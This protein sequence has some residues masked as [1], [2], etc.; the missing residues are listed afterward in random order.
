MPELS[1]WDRLSEADKYKLWKAGMLSLKLH[2]GQRKIYDHI[3]AWEKAELK[4]RTEELAPSPGVYADVYYACCAR[5]F[6]KDFL[7][8]LMATE[9]CLRRKN[10][11]FS[12]GT[13]FQNDI[14]DICIALMEQICQDAPRE[15]RP[16]LQMANQAHPLRYYFPS[17]KSV[18]KLVGLDRNPDGLRGRHSDGVFLSEAAFI[19][20]LE[21]TI[22][23]VVGAMF[24]NRPW[25]NVLMNSTPPVD[26][27]HASD[28]VFWP[29]CELR[30][31]YTE[32]TIYD[33]PLLSPFTIEEELR[34]KGGKDSPVA[35]REYLC[36]RVRQEDRVVLPE[37]S[38]AKHVS[39]FE[40]PQFA[41]AFTVL[42]PGVVDLCGV[43]LIV[44]DFESGRLLVVDEWAKA[45]ASTPEVAQAIRMLEGQ[46]LNNLSYWEVDKFKQN[47]AARYSDTEARLI[48]DMRTEHQIAIQPVDKR[49]ADAAIQALRAALTMNRILIHP[50]CKQLIAHC[51]NAVWNKTRSS[52]E[53]SER[54]G[55]YDLVDVIKYAYRSINR[56]ANPFPPPGAIIT[57]FG[58]DFADKHVPP[59]T[60][61]TRS[62]RGGLQHLAKLLPGRFYKKR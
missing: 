23:S 44:N 5:R 13:A 2:S 58:T 26:P 56:T 38:E 40:I 27:G 42:D 16:V 18:L 9:K 61:R 41:Q 50:R 19:D 55:H 45:G 24:L 32:A 57:K 28:T 21:Y 22:Q 30:G 47:P 11:V 39:V 33:N 48:L 51:N 25:A 12:Y 53:R 15:I 62:N 29:D 34:K 17:T 36:K 1:P 8:L 46:Y 3:Q 4:R 35:Q 14:A 37:F 52:Y 10:G 6:G 7:Y 60:L 20:K 31:A 43:L 49:D 54:Y 59:H